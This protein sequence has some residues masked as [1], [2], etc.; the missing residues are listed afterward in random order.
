M[1]FVDVPDQ[2]LVQ[3]CRSNR[4]ELQDSFRAL[5]ERH[6]GAAFHYLSALVG[7]ERAL[8]ALQETFL[9]VYRN[10]DRYDSGRSFRS[11]VLGV[12]RNVGL[13]T[14]RREGVRA[15]SPLG[16]ETA[17]D[18]H[19]PAEEASRREQDTLLRQSVCELPPDQRA[20]LLLRQIEGLG[21]KEI[22]ATLGIA[23]RTAQYRM[24]RAVERLAGSLRRRG[25]IPGGAE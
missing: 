25:L 11:W 18:V 4:A 17:L 13:D 14:I 2:D 22:A 6:S 21:Y 16:H 24:R 10:L 15:T 9:R 1:G 3:R 19:G 20:V 23:E 8:D 7:R 5:Y 12:A